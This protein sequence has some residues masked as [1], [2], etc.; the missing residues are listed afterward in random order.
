MEKAKIAIKPPTEL[1]K[2]VEILKSRGLFF[3]NDTEAIRTLEHINYYRLRG[4]YIH[5][6]K[7]DIFE[8]G[9]S[10]NQIVALHNFDT[11]LRLLLLSVLLDVEI[12]A[13]ARISYIIAHAWGAMGY[14]EKSNYSCTPD[15]VDEL[16]DK[17]DADLKQSNERFIKTHQDKYGGQF[18]IWVAVEVMSFG[19]L[20]KLYS[21]LPTSLKKNVANSYDYLDE[22]LLTN[23][24]HGAS[25]LRNV[26]AHNGRIYNR[27]VPTPITI[28]TETLNHINDIT[29]G[30]FKVYAQSLFAYLLALRRISTKETWDEF[31]SGFNQL[32]GKYDGL[33][34]LNR[35][36][37]PFQWK[38]ILTR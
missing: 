4:Y 29:G 12:V 28:E 32:V 27:N 24:I 33:I 5:L 26:C 20:S 9:V 3:D 30:K 38:V 34:E 36:G 2:Q 22:K 7:E 21:L 37:M 35:M 23:W 8:K 15:K 6:Q 16:M 31:M 18:P 17:L 25:V 1:E 14:R 10:F 13:R 11:E 19:D